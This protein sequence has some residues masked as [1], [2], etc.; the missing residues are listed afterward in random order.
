MPWQSIP[1]YIAWA[2]VTSSPVEEELANIQESIFSAFY[3]SRPSVSS[4]WISG[5]SFKD[6]EMKPSH[7]AHGVQVLISDVLMT[8]LE[9]QEGLRGIA[10]FQMLLCMDP[11]TDPPN[12][13]GVAPQ[14]WVIT[15][16]ICAFINPLSHCPWPA[17]QTCSWKNSALFLFPQ[18]KHLTFVLQL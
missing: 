3:K 6:S 17:E 5:D 4:V 14:A 18:L 15:L 9:R 12:Q 11:W 8:P 1:L 7:P 2:K 10:L 13:P 16:L